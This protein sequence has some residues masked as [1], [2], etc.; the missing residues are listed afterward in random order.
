LSRLSVDVEQLVLQSKPR[1]PPQ[2]AWKMIMWEERQFHPLDYNDP[3]LPGP[4]R[5]GDLGELNDI[6][7]AVIPNELSP[8]IIREK[9]L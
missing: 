2:T 7:L 8:R 9:E 3:H 4:V 1:E 5:G 6:P